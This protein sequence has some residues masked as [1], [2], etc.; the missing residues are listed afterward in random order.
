MYSR[1]SDDDI[2]VALDGPKQTRRHKAR[3]RFMDRFHGSRLGYIG[4]IVG[5]AAW[6]GCK[7]AGHQ[8]FPEAPDQC[9][10]C[11]TT[12]DAGGGAQ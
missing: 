7:I 6:A 5:S 10:H 3:N 1:M 2:D 11:G 12:L 4:W 9:L 8:P